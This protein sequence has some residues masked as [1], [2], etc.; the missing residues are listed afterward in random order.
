MSPASADGGTHRNVCP[1]FVA[2]RAVEIGGFHA[3]IIGVLKVLELVLSS[4]S[5]RRFGQA[6]VRFGRSSA[7]TN[8]GRSSS[9]PDWISQNSPTISHAISE[10]LLVK[11][12]CRA[13]VPLARDRSGPVPLCSLAGRPRTYDAEHALETDMVHAEAS[14]DLHDQE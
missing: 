13:A 5:G 10:N 11:C 9:F 7:F 4:S 1:L 14:L 8:S 6:P 2:R 3:R 12:R